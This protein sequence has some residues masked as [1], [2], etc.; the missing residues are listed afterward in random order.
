[1]IDCI[2]AEGEE[3]EIAICADYSEP[4]MQSPKPVPDLVTTIDGPCPQPK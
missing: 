2:N 1:M 3:T 4:L